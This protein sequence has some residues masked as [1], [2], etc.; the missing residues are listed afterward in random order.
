M[1]GLIA[2]PNIRAPIIWTGQWDI[3][4]PRR[5]EKLLCNPNTRLRAT[6]IAVGGIYWH[7]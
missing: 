1:E 3:D 5:E 6:P 7:E 2:R 4:L